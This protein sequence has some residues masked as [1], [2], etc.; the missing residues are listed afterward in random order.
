MVDTFRNDAGIPELGDWYGI[1]RIE[2]IPHVLIIDASDPDNPR[3]AL[4]CKEELMGITLP[5][6]AFQEDNDVW[7]GRTDQ[8]K[9]LVAPSTAEADVPRVSP[10]S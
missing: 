6:R 10:D 1:L 3:F 2:G 9:G 5:D 7:L 8:E 4:R